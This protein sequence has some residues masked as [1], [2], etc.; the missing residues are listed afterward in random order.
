M[1]EQSFTSHAGRG[2][3]HKGS[4]LE[5]IAAD[6]VEAMDHASYAEQAAVAPG[7][8][9]RVD[10]RVKLIGHLLLILTAISVRSLWV[11]AGLL[12]CA[13][14]LAIL[15]RVSVRAVMFRIWISVLF[16][17]G[18]L[19]LPAMV[20]VSGDVVVRAPIIGWTIT[21][22]GMMS[23]GFLIGRA[24]TCTSLAV[25]LILCT[26]W[27]HLLKALKVFRVPTVF[28]VI[29]GMTERYIFLFLKT[30][31][32][33]FEA[34]RSR[35]LAPVSRRAA[36][37]I[38]VANAGVLLSK[39][40]HL[41]N[42]V[43]QAMISRGYRGKEFTLEDFSMQSRDWLTLGAFLVTAAVALWLGR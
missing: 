30:A 7:F 43:H 21:Q 28:I 37:R 9:Q 16:F 32:E 27:P 18:V 38:A 31:L 17:T 20:L 11:I 25:L 1:A 39:S 23:A 42:E 2:H 29:L 35:M 34:K 10:P 41:S 33:M 14:V 36:R 24:L 40:L 15:S 4:F 3:H 8:L 19:A 13:T 5:R 12:A 22:Q 6:L 26:P